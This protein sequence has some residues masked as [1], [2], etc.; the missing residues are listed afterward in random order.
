M[1]RINQI[2]KTK[3]FIFESLVELLKSKIFEDITLSEIAVQAKVSRMT[4]HRHFNGKEDI[5]SFGLEAQLDDMVY[6]LRAVENRTI[7]DLLRLRF[8]MLQA[9]TH[10]LTLYKHNKLSNL[11]RNIGV[12]H[13]DEFAVLFPRFEDKYFVSFIIGGIDLLTEQ[14][15]ANDMKE[16]YEEITQ[17]VLKV[18]KE[19]CTLV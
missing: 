14:W 16:D 15:I 19:M 9:S 5:I 8:K 3:M 17:R 13:M 12:K 6:Q 2:N 11:S 7:E 1:R 18:I 10:T 4:I